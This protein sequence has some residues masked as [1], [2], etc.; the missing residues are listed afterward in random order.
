MEF[1]Q[2]VGVFSADDK[3][4]GHLE[5]VVIDP[6]TN[7]VTHLIV[8][9][10]LVVPQDKV[11]PIDQVEVG[12]EDGIVMRLTTADFEQLPE[13]EETQFVAADEAKWER[14][15]PIDPVG[16]APAIYWLP[17]YPHSPLLPE[18]VEPG[19][20][21]ETQLN[22]P[23]GTI[24]V[25]EGAQVISRDGKRTGKVDEVLTA[26]E[27]DRITHVLITQG[28]LV[29]AQ[30]LIPIGWIDVLSED[31]VHLV[32]RSSTVDKLPDYDHA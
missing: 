1:K 13:F 11:L 23:A 16:N 24:A 28:L 4:I 20:R 32:V 9:H 12:T 26:T 17:V 27:S 8:R 25:K 3:A 2:H 19:Y 21:V 14:T 15:G 22:I 30:K 18:F 5:R 7:E 6:K 29:K 10:G 31:E